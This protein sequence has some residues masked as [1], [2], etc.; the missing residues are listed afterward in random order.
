MLRE[1]IYGVVVRGVPVGSWF[2]RS[3]TLRILGLSG[4]VA[5][6]FVWPVLALDSLSFSTPGADKKLR[7]ALISA[8]LVAQAES[9]SAADPQDLFAAARTDYGRL[10][11]ALYAEGYYS[12]VVRILLD[13][14]EAADFAAI[15]APQAISKINIVVEPG[16]RFTFLRARMKPY[17]PG[18]KLPSAYGDTKVARSTAIADAARAGVEGWRNLGH[19]KAAVAGQTIIADHRAAKI[20]A[21]ILLSAGPRVSFGKLNLKG[22]QGMS[23]R[24][25]VQISGY[26]E[27]ERFSPETLRKMAARLRRTGVYRSVAIHEAERL[28]PDDRLDIDLTLIEEAPR[29]FGFG[30][31]ISS[32]DG[33]NLSAFWLHRNLFGGGERFRLDGLIKGIGSSSAITEYQLGA[34]IDRP[35]T[36]FADS[37][38]FLAAKIDQSEI[39]DLEVKSAS[40][41]FGLTRVINDRLTAEAGLTYVRSSIQDS[42]LRVDFDV[43][44]L[45]L[46]ITWDRRNS[47]LSPTKGIYADLSATPFLGFGSTDSGAQLKADLRAYKSMSADDRLTLAGRL[48]LGTVLGSAL[49]NTPP[50]YLFYSGGGG[51]VR[52]HPFQSLGVT[53]Q[54]ANGITYQSGG[55]SFVGLSG[56]L[57]AA[58][59][60]TL[61]AAVFY[62]AGW[63]TAGSS[64]SGQSQW[65]TGAGVGLRYDTGFGPVRLDVALPVSGA[66]GN[67]MQVY[68]G[69]GQ[70]F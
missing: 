14:R 23:T 20:D 6:G 43:L 26:H 70:A 24:R 22:Q 10:L 41:G 34:R 30:A 50:D 63:I 54:L 1:V 5:L 66:T 60:E 3:D 4:V 69:I 51:T 46:S 67:G 33:A 11:G 9:D 37:S 52:G 45:P 42:T 19:A 27:G 28:S 55:Q 57:R 2:K 44:A 7:A 17:A 16:V 8:S 64:F 65:Q 40:L 32:A 38:A 53:A 56:E 61:G 47:K 29:R 35:G 12:G 49:A 39:L 68:V 31:E 62:D 59:S 21:E 58:I 15:D 48:Q 25:I 36:P 18:T 13:G